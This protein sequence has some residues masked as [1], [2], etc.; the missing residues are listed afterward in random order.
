MPSTGRHAIAMLPSRRWRANNPPRVAMRRRCSVVKSPRGP[1]P[2]QSARRAFQ[3]SPASGVNNCSN[4]LPRNSRRC[5]APPYSPPEAPSSSGSSL[6]LSSSQ[7]IVTCRSPGGVW[8]RAHTATAP[9]H[10]AAQKPRLSFKPT[11]PAG[12]A[13]PPGDPVLDVGGGPNDYGDFYCPTVQWDWDDGTISETS[14]DCDPYE[15]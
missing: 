1:A 2:T 14:E 7:T 8:G 5:R 10:A 15:G 11:P 12:I 3:P 6:K 9:H 13:P 4:G